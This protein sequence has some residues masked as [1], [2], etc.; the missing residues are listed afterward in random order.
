MAVTARPC[1]VKCGRPDM[2]ELIGKAAAEVAAAPAPAA[3]SL[4]AGLY[5]CVCGP[6]AMV[7]SCKDAVRQV[8][9]HQRGVPI[10]LH[11]EDPDW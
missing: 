8:R 7:K 6:A 2:A 3:S 5:V 9:R 11:V 1:A 10:G 4:T